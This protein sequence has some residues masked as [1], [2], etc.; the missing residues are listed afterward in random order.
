M[1]AKEIEQ[2]DLVTLVFGHLRAAKLVEGVLTGAHE[3]PPTLIVQASL[4]S[5]SRD[6]SL[7]GFGDRCL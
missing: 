3:L 5:Q 4:T 1:I 6:F 2:R 7:R